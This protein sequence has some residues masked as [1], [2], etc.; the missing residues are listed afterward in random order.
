VTGQVGRRLVGA[1]IR[2][3]L[4]VGDLVPGQRLIAQELADRHHATRSC[5][6]EALQDLASERLVELMPHRGARVRVVTV[7]E[8][9]QI[10]ECR[11]ALEALC[12]RRAADRATPG[13]RDE[14]RAIGAH[15]RDAVAQGDLGVYGALNAELHDRIAEVSCQEVA[16]G[17][18]NR[19]KGQ[20]VRHQFRL[21]LRPGRPSKSLPQH[22][23]IIEAIASGDGPAS[24]AAA[25]AHLSS[26]IDELR[27]F[28][29][30]GGPG[31]HGAQA[32]A[33]RGPRW[34]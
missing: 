16:Y 8:A 6:R 4:S 10:T 27:A 7:E 23:A 2:E 19:L 5:V 28:P 12:A 32:P 11:A 30:G 3:A 18:L 31:P 1:A 20:M 15:M 17:L 26:V 14:L 22:L 33:P 9:I 34:E 13:Q 29:S 24:E 25:L 21:A